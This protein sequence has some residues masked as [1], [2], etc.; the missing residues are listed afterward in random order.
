M[1]ERCDVVIIG[2]RLAGAC[3]AAHLARAGRRVVALDRS[4]FPS[5][6]LSTH[7]LFPAGV[8]ELRRMGALEGILGQNPTRSPWLSLSTDESA[9]TLERWRACGPIDYCMC[10]PR[11][12]QDLELVRAARAAG[13]EVR[14]RHRFLDVLWRGGRAVGVRYADAEGTERELHADLV[15]GADGRRSAVAAAVGAFKPYRASRNGRGLVFRYVDDPAFG[16]REGETVYQWRDGDSFGFL[17]P[18]APSPKSLLLFMGAADEATEAKRDPEGYWTRKL[19][20]HPGMAARVRDCT[21]PGPLRS[22]GDTSAYFRASSGPGWALV[23]DSG[24]FKDPVIGQGQRDALWAARRLAETVG[25][26]LGDPGALDL[27]LRRWE[28]DR[29]TECLHSYHFGNLETE[30][31]PVSPVLH[32]IV[33]RNGRSSAPDIGDVFGRGRTTT[34]V[35]SV[36]RLVLGLADA[37]RRRTGDSPGATVRL[38]LDDLRVH[39]ALRQDLLGRRFRSA[40]L[41]PG[42]DH[43][44]PRP[45]TLPRGGANPAGVTNE[46]AAA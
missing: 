17:F 30:V 18:S 34:Q 13:A 43:P 39:L 29:D 40:R 35:L 19:A 20:Q 36:P 5:D 12:I 4:S 41:V 44:D 33:R 21:N 8:D 42:S 24:H 25:P 27:A 46:G 3:V 6:Q 1:T 26:V 32:E 16:T 37:L 7:L 22:T 23:G 11:T 15:L 31:R 10:V 14:E 38:A 45:P 2:S 9:H 28:R